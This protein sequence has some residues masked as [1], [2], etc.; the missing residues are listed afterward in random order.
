MSKTLPTIKR[1]IIF[2]ILAAI[3][4]WLNMAVFFTWTSYFGGEEILE[5]YQ[6]DSE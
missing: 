6:Q 3:A 1:V 5:L 4:P 2:L